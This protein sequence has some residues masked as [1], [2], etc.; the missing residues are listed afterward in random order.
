MKKIEEELSLA[1]LSIDNQQIYHNLSIEYQSYLNI[2]NYSY[3]IYFL[4]FQAK[5]RMAAILEIR[6][7]IKKGTAIMLR[8]DAV[9]SESG[10]FSKKSAPVANLTPQQREELFRQVEYDPSEANAKAVSPQFIYAAISFRL[11]TTS[12]TLLDNHVPVA[13]L[14]AKSALTTVIVHPTTKK[15]SF[16]LQ[17]LGYL[18]WVYLRSLSF[19]FFIRSK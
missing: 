14:V 12:L 2:N 8:A 9:K 11:E 10:W 6:A 3:S 17:S 5:F 15:L 19:D 16:D 7:Q 1:E 18:L 13:S 4:R